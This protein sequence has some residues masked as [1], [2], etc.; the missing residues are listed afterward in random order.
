M[1]ANKDREVFFFFQ[2]F[3][4]SRY[5]VLKKCSTM[6]E[7]GEITCYHFFYPFPF[8][9]FNNTIASLLFFLPTVGGET[10]SVL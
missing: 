8:Q 10:I 2:S 3:V 1:S 4:L 5:T 7:L 9:V 6:K